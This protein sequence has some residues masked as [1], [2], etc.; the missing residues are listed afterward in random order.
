MS[1]YQSKVADSD[2]WRHYSAAEDEIWSTLLETQLAMLAGRACDEFIHCLTALDLPPERVP[3]LAEVNEKLAVESGWQ[4]TAVDGMTSFDDFFTMLGDCCFP[5][6]TFIRTREDL[7]FVSQPDIFHEV[8]GHG[9]L[10]MHPS[11]AAFSQT[12]GKT[13]VGQTA[14]FQKAL[15]AVYWYTCE[16]G[17]LQ[18]ASGQNR[19][20][21][22]STIS[23]PKE[24][25]HASS[26]QQAELRPFSIPDMV[27]NSYRIDELTKTYYQVPSLAYLAT[28]SQSELTSSIE[29]A[30]DAAAQTKSPQLENV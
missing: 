3:Q 14:A 11:Y 30:L 12:I 10:L 25:L 17:A 18:D 5:A 19:L 22:A 16:T 26:G 23:S 8:F 15:A 9:P 28:I 1:A 21:G 2:G 7:E 20:Y 29:Q 13:G 24:I 4:L 27:L 6:A